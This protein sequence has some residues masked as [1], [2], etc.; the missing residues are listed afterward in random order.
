LRLLSLPWPL[1]LGLGGLLR[2][3][4]RCLLMGLLS[5]LLSLLCLESRDLSLLDVDVLGIHGVLVR[6]ACLLTHLYLLLLLKGDL[7][8]EHV[9]LQNVC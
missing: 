6:V 8:C 1:L 2:C 4:L 9:G 5:L 7:L 3:L